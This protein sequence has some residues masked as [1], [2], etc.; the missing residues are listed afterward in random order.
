MEL[1]IP[2]SMKDKKEQLFRED[3]FTCPIYWMDKPEWINKLNKASDPYIK[4]AKKLND[5]HIKE[6]VETK[7]ED[8]KVPNS[9]LPHR[10][11]GRLRCLP[12]KDE[13][14]VNGGFV[15]GETTARNERRYV[16]E[17]Q[18][19]KINYK[20]DGI[21]QVK[22]ELISEEKLTPFATMINIKL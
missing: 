17:M 4:K 14:I 13:G 19:D 5:K 8:I 7:T 6:N 22:Y 18:Q 21:K 16:L 2:F 12:H 3:Y 10:V 9:I 20:S 15:K 11:E 1:R